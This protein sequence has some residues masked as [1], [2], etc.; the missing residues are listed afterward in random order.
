MDVAV[1]GSTG[2]IGTALG[3]E[4]RADGHRVLR[5]VRHPAGPDEATWDPERGTIDAAALEGIGAV[6]HLAGAGIADKRWSEAR[7]QEI[8]GSR[9]KGT[10]LL[11]A[12]LAGLSSPPAVLL[13]GSAIGWYGDR[14]DEVLTESSTSGQGFL[15]E[16][17]R[18]WEAATAPAE[19]A[20]VR[21]AHLRTGLVLA[22]GG[23]MLKRMAPLFR[24]AL[25][26]RL[27][28]GRQWWPWVALADEVGAIRWLLDHDVHG[29]VNLT[30]PTPVTNAQFTRVLADVVH[31]PAVLPVPEFGPELLLGR[32][33][34]RQLL[35]S[36]AR[37]LPA[38]L[39]SAGYP[40]RQAELRPALESALHRP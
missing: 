22:P 31:R 35:F 7:R 1:T 23:G 40:F 33:L 15:P 5:V 29:P 38:V 11:A 3:N 14:G 17:C 21:V 26:G 16:V 6:V 4:L 37:V 28:S 10:H 12:T 36:S 32:D 25:G 13:S 27:G 9:E 20:G 18:R 30:A 34:A 19:A 39:Q 2:L 24:F 8:L